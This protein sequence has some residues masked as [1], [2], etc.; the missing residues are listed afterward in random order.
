VRSTTHAGLGFLGFA[1]EER[2]RSSQV[3]CATGGPYTTKTRLRPC[4]QIDLA[5]RKL[6][7]RLRPQCC[8]AGRPPASSS[9]SDRPTVERLR[10]RPQQ[11]VFGQVRLNLSHPAASR[12]CHAASRDDS[13]VDHRDD[14]I[15]FAARSSD[16]CRWGWDRSLLLTGYI[17]CV[18]L[19][20]LL[21]NRNWLGAGFAR[22]LCICFAGCERASWYCV[23]GPTRLS[24]AARPKDLIELRR[25][26]SS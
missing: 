12:R 21:R 15:R 8:V 24:A 7:D 11:I 4:C 1:V 6:S 10:P 13:F 3:E 20:A 16:S 17:V 18:W 22:S 9:D 26:E 2:L 25:A 23:E 5:H 14:G 19:A